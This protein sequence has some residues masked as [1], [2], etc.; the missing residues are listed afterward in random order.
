[1]MMTPDTR[2]RRATHSIVHVLLVLT[3]LTGCASTVP[4]TKPVRESIRSVSINKEVKVA[5]NMSYYGPG[6]GLGPLFGLIGYAIAEAVSRGPSAKLNAAMQEGQID[7]AQIVRE[8]FESELVRAGIFPAIVAEA[9]DAEIRLE[10]REFGFAQ[11]FDPLDRLKPI[12]RVLGSLTRTDG[13]VLWKKDEHVTNRNE[14]TPDHTLEEYLQ[15][16]QITREAFTVAAKI[17][18]SGLV[19]DL[20]GN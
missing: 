18:A 14:Q 17:V 15:N 4:L 13:T 12:L 7:L 20:R 3:L 16:S 9:R 5:D 19:S 8:Q 10:V 2:L 6:Q 11:P 1:M